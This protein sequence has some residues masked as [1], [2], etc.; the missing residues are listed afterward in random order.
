MVIFV[1]YTK[2]LAFVLALPNSFFPCSCKL[3]AFILNAYVKVTVETS[4]FQVP[5]SL[6]FELSNACGRDE[7][8]RLSWVLVRALDSLLL[9]FTSCERWREPWS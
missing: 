1:H 9:F 6:G 7:D 5:V 3:S 4:L 2:L 8:L